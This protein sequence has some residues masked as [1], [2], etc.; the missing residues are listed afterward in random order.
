MVKVIV[1][2]GNPGDKYKATKH[3]IGFMALDNIAEKEGATFTRDNTFLAD[4]ASFHKNGEKIYLV[5]PVTFMNDSGKSVG[6]L[7]AY[8]GLSEA[9][10]LVIYDDLDLEV[11]KLRLRQ[12]GSAGGHNGIKSLI[13]HLGSQNFKRLKIGIGRP[14]NGMSVVNH[15]LSKFD[16]DD[17]PEVLSA[18]DT[19]E[20]IVEDYLDNNDF[21][22]AMNKYNGK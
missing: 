1:G 9:E 17:E 8:Y 12:K 20:Q 2:L 16:S 15:V 5:K 14:K 10:L 13:S 18:L 21:V 22:A 4:I 6:P 3:N 11:G 19:S 7:L